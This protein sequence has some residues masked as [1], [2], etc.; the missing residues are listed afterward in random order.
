[1]VSTD[2]LVLN[3]RSVCGGLRGARGVAHKPIHWRAGWNFCELANSRDP[4]CPELLLSMY[5]LSVPRCTSERHAGSSSPNGETLSPWFVS[6][7]EANTGIHA[8][9]KVAAEKLGEIG[10]HTF[11]H[12]YR[13]WL[14]ETGAPMK[15]QRELMR[16]ASIQTTMNI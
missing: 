13:S 16:R 4:T 6:R 9:R 10:C 8:R 14:D 1:M 7:A 3:V 2:T 12:T 15:V 11:R 5:R